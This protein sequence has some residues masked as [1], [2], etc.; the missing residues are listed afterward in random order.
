MK[1]VVRFVL[2]FV[3]FAFVSCACGSNTATP[4]ANPVGDEKLVQAQKEI[5]ELKQKLEQANQ[6]IQQLQSTP[7]Q[8]YQILADRADKIESGAEGQ[9]LINDIDDFVKKNPQHALAREASALK[10]K[11]AKKLQTIKAEESRQAAQS[12]LKA[13]KEALEGIQDGADLDTQRMV[14]LAELLKKTYSLSVLKMLPKT[15]YKEAMKDA[16]SVRGA[17]VS[18]GGTIIEIKKEEISP[19]FVVYEGGLMESEL[20]V[21]RF[22]AIGGTRGIYEGSYAK[23]VGVFSQIYSYPNVTGG[24]THAIA[25]VGYFDIPENQR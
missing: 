3:L 15:N 5:A 14:K 18:A 22:I 21:V 24:E 1:S 2:C 11:V 6:L 12:A 4:V 9:Q 8:R 23:F 20:N 17:I 16:D 7:E 19:G 25:V 13:F 10:V